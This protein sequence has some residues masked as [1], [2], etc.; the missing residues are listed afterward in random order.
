MLGESLPSCKGLEVQTFNEHRNLPTGARRQDFHRRCH[1]PF[2]GD[3]LIT[4]QRGL[5]ERQRLGNSVLIVERRICSSCCESHVVS[6]FKVSNILSIHSKVSYISFLFA[7]DQQVAHGPLRA[8][9]AP[10]GVVE[11]VTIVH[12]RYQGDFL[13]TMRSLLPSPQCLF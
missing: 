1:I 11:L 9:Q 8:H 6:S 5:L 12:A 13:T 2:G 4:A 10:G 7:L 3:R